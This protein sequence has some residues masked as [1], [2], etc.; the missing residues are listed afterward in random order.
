MKGFYD[1]GYHKRNSVLKGYSIR[2][3]EDHC[4][5]SIQMS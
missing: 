5:K 2:K 4:T 1:W 3:A